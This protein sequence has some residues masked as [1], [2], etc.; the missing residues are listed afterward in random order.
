MNGAKVYHS[1]FGILETIKLRHTM[2]FVP[3]VIMA[4]T[5]H[6]SSGFNSRFLVY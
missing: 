3:T 5:R 2:Y 6:P 1:K 4:G